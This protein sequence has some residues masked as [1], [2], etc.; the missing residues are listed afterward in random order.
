MFSEPYSWH[1]A[2]EGTVIRMFKH[3]SE[4]QDRWYISNHRKLD[5]LMSRWG[6]SISFGTLFS[7]AIKARVQTSPELKSQMD[8]KTGTLFHQFKNKILDPRYLYVF[9]LTTNPQTRIVSGSLGESEVYHVGS[10]NRID[11][12]WD[13]DHRLVGIPRPER[14]SPD[15]IYGLD[16]LFFSP[17]RTESRFPLTYQGVIGIRYSDDR[18]AVQTLKIL[19]SDYVKL[20]GHPGK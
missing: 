10:F 7:D 14:V 18:T 5:A 11:Q 13:L 4:T 2:Y 1:P 17:A 15:Q 9:L 19:N 16:S 6:S 8:L 20:A 12:K 3:T